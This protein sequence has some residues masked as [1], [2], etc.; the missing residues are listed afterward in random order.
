MKLVLV[1]AVEE[2]Q[3]EVLKIF[4]KANIKN[5]SSSDIDGY[6]NSP[7]LLMASSWFSGEKSGNESR[8]FFSF[9]EK[10]KIDDLFKLMEEFNKELKT[11]NPLKAI[12]LPIEKFI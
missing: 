1:T 10:E 12:V 5:F 6:K 8:M 4:K 2:F 11:N 9:T 3:K 7:E